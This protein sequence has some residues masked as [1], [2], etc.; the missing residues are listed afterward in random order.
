MSDRTW[1]QKQVAEDLEKTS[2]QEVENAEHAAKQ[3]LK[4]LHH[5][6]RAL[7]NKAAEFAAACGQA[8]G[9][10]S[11]V[12]AKESLSQYN[13]FA[14]VGS[15]TC[16]EQQRNIVA[17]QLKAAHQ[18]ASKLQLMHNKTRDAHESLERAICARVQA[19]KDAQK[20]MTEADKVMKHVIIKKT[21]KEV[22]REKNVNVKSIDPVSSNITIHI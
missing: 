9:I 14:I 21:K 16:L 4:D 3:Q 10:V 12:Q 17:N 1:I 7:S 18:E 11:Q 19:V 6:I 8:A 13:V 2:R 15:V 20:A 22:Q 5:S